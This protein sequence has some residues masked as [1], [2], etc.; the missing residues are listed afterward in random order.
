MSSTTPIQIEN[1]DFSYG[2]VSV[3]EKANLTL[4]DREFV[5]IVGPN[6]GGKTTLLKIIL[7]LLEPRNGTVSIFGNTP[8]VGR[9]QIGYLPQYANLDP[10]FPVTA[11]DVILM[12]LLGQTRR[13]GFYTRSDKEAAYS[14]LAHVGLDKLRNRPLSALSGG[15]R[16]RV[17]IARALVSKPKL[18][19]LYLLW[20]LHKV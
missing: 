5:S 16:Q 1:L 10:K 4:G 7:G 3:L 9:K 11:C 14:I 19:L 8:V 2:T 12:G 13:F 17:L 18:L 15:Q 6:G 20:F